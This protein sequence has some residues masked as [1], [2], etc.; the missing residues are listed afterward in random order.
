M[1]R[2]PESQGMQG[3]IAKMLLAIFA[4]TVYGRSH[5]DI[6]NLSNCRINT[7]AGRSGVFAPTLLGYMGY[8]VLPLI[9]CRG[10]VTAIFSA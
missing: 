8:T 2:A 10:I 4:R 6:A 1:I 5:A 9:T 3:K 7:I